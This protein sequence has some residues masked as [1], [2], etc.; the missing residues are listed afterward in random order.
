[1]KKIIFGLFSIATLLT[2]SSCDED[3][4]IEEPLFQEIYTGDIKDEQEMSWTVNNI[5]NSLGSGSAFGADLIL[6][7]DMISE[8]VFIS[9][10][11][12]SGYYT[13][14]NALN[15]S[16]DAG[17]GFW[18]ALY[19]VVQKANFVILDEN[20]PVTENVISYK[21]EAK[22]AKGLANFYLVQLYSSNPTSGQHQETGIP[23]INEKYDPT[24]FGSRN[25]VDE[26]Y[27]QII[28]DLTEGINEMSPTMRSSKT[29]LSPTAGKLILS[30]VYLTRGKA[31]DYDKAIQLAD[32]ILTS[33]PSNFS[34]I[35]KTGLVNYFTSSSV[36]NYE[37]QP[38]TIFEIEQN[39]N[40]SLNVNAHLATFYSN[41]GAHR[42]FFVRNWVYKLF[43][44]SDER[45]KLFSTGGTTTGEFANDDPSGV[46]TRKYPRAVGGGWSGNIKV[47]RMTEAKYIKME[48]LAKKGDNTALTLLNEHAVE[49]GA[50]PYSGDALTAIL[51][52][53]QKEFL[54]EGHRFYDL[55]RN[56]LGF[57]K[58]TNCFNNCQ[59]G[60]DSKFFVFPISLSERLLNPN[61]TQHPVWQ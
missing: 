26:V 6:Y 27:D 30:K 45:K 40:Y 4:L 33:S 61:M 10:G 58:Q 7:G 46:F 21:G 53:K 55:K 49:R 57:D 5:Y 36:A 56:N 14:I 51:L 54:T 42:G 25:T 12:T 18:R 17:F 23:L 38:E 29:F 34:L 47:F 24:Y 32:E 39:P 19:D 1:M 22:I 9:V 2:F 31:G 41:Q 35:T 20:V 16:G 43:E 52:D 15:W 48:A 3:R 60:A 11:N 59:F 13:N 50:T 44:D 37:E 8:N 28:K